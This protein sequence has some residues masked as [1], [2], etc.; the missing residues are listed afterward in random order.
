MSGFRAKAVIPLRARK[1]SPPE[2]EVPPNS[3]PIPPEEGRG[4]G[5]RGCRATFRITGSL[6]STTRR[7][8]AS[9]SAHADHETARSANPRTTTNQK[10][11]KHSRAV[12]DISLK[13]DRGYALA[14]FAQGEVRWPAT[15]WRSKARGRRRK[16]KRYAWK[17]CRHARWRTPMVGHGEGITAALVAARRRKPVRA[18][19]SGRQVR[20]GN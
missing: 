4:R 16:S 14:K 2:A 5:W 9:R 12:S 17:P 10:R 8:R 20:G 13:W 15:L 6:A 7:N 19:R 1:A 3:S 18:H 11:L